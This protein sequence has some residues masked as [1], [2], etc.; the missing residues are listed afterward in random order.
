MTPRK[1]RPKC[2]CITYCNLILEILINCYAEDKNV[3][4]YSHISELSY[5]VFQFWIYNINNSGINSCCKSA[6]ATWIFERI[7]YT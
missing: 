2:I 1:I 5:Y 6:S 4:N 7:V 3:S